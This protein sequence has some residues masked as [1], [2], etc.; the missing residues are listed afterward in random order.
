MRYSVDYY[1]PFPK[2]SYIPDQLHHHQHLNISVVDFT[3]VSLKPNF[4]GDS[5][6]ETTFNFL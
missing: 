2:S 4:I 1:I 3:K 6:M 5:K